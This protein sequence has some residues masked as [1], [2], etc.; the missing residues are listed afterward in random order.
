M[1]TI[2]KFMKKVLAP[3]FL[4]LALNL[5]AQEQAK[6]ISATPV[7]QMVNMTQQVCTNTPIAV[8]Q[9]KSGAGALMG[10]IAGGAI[11]NSMG[12]GS[13]NAAAT[14]IGVMGGP[15]T[16]QQNKLAYYDIKYEFGGKQYS[17]QMP[18]DPGPFI[19]VS[20]KPQ[21][22]N[23]IVNPTVASSPV[24]GVVYVVPAYPAPGVG[25]VWDFHPRFG[26]GWRH[27]GYGWH[28]GWR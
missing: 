22:D 6:V 9:P 14:A 10:A 8:N 17:V 25:W 2:S 19:N 3:G 15:I 24:P 4:F 20:I 26:W 7:Y 5:M 23:Q 21:I 12:H 1:M 27:P 13:G 18:N 11:G 16:S 28:R